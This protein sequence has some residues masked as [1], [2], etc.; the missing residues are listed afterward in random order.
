M[1]LTVPIPTSGMNCMCMHNM[2]TKYIVIV[3]SMCMDTV[4]VNFAFDDL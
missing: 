4:Y 3:C 1:F 2:Y